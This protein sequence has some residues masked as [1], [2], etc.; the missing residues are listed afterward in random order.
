MEIGGDRANG[1][2]FRENCSRFLVA[3][4]VLEIRNRVTYAS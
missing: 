3:R 4:W 1:L 2:D